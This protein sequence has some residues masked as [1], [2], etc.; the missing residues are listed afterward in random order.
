MSTTYET[1]V[2]LLPVL[3]SSICRV[4]ILIGDA[5]PEAMT[6]VD[7]AFDTLCVSVHHSPRYPSC[8]YRDPPV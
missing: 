4:I 1:D 3:S 6:A 7:A 5:T 2:P 8:W